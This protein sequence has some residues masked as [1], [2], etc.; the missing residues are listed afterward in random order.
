MEKKENANLVLGY[1]KQT[2]ANVNQKNTTDR[3]SLRRFS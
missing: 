1:F 3:Y 2:W